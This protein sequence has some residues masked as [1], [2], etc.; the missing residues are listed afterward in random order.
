MVYLRYLNYV[1]LTYLNVLTGFYLWA[2]LRPQVYYKSFN[3]D[4]EFAKCVSLLPVN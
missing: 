2:S 3:F 4:L 1:I